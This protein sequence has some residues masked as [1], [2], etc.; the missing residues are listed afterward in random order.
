[1]VGNDTTSGNNRYI[2]NIFQ[3]NTEEHILIGKEMEY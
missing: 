3:N 2:R 1:M